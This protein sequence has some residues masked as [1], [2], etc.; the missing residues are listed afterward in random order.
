MTAIEAKKISD[1]YAKS[2]ENQKKLMIEMIREASV[3]G[4]YSVSLLG[5]SYEIKVWLVENGYRVED[6]HPGISSAIISWNLA[7]SESVGKM[8]LKKLPWHKKL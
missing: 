8:L 5:P 1:G 2:I 4:K 3:R 6:P 7:V